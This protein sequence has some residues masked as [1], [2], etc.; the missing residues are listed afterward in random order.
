MELFG[1]QCHDNTHFLKKLQIERDL[2]QIQTNVAVLVA[3]MMHSMHLHCLWNVYFLAAQIHLLLHQS[4]FQML[5][6][7]LLLTDP[8]HP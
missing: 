5:L 6:Q 7:Y 4:P 8:F 2:L 3:L 1:S